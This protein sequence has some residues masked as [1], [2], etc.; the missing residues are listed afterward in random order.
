[1]LKIGALFFN[2]GLMGYLS[3]A[4]VAVGNYWMPVCLIGF[5]W[6]NYKVSC[7]EKDY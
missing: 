5:V 3:G 6:V 7:E 2:T 1:M 4:L